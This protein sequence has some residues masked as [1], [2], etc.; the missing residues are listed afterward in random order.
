MEQIASL[1]PYTAQKLRREMVD[2]LLQVCQEHFE[3]NHLTTNASGGNT[4]L[5]CYRKV[6]ELDPNNHEAKQGLKDIEERYKTWAEMAL[7]KKKLDKARTYLA[8]LEKV[9]PQS[10]DL[11]VLKQ[12]LE[13]AESK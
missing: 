5:V 10:P 1:N 8:S 3:A 12:R 13:E 9:N 4:A 11:P 7:Q 2:N 6:Q